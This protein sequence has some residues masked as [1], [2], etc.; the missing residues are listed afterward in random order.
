[1]LNRTAGS[2]TQ[3]KR[4]IMGFDKTKINKLLTIDRQSGKII[5][6]TSNQF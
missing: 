2:Y 4:N 3:F 6:D 1:M 5:H